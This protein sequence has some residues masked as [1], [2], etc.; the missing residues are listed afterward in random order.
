MEE[1]LK[2]PVTFFAYP[3]GMKS[4]GDI[5]DETAELLVEKG[6]AL[7]CTSEMGRNGPDE[8]IYLLKRMGIGR[9]DSLDLFRAKLAGA[10]DWLGAAQKNFQRVFKNV[11]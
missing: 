7:A 6:Y 1:N 11:C 10:C 2:Q 9:E 3:F 8:N 5:N 4:Y